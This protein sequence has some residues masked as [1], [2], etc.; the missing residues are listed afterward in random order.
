MPGQDFSHVNSREEAIE[1]CEAGQLFKILLF[2]AELGGEDTPLNVVYV[3]AGIPGIKDRLTGAL[4]RFYQEGLIDQLSI[5][6][7]YKGDSIVPSKIQ[8]K[9]WHSTK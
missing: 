3:P 8:I 9:A 4:T 7:V 1:L 2:P 5:K 6:P